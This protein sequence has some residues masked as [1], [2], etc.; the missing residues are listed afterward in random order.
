VTRPDVI[1]AS[2]KLVFDRRAGFVKFHED[3]FIVACGNRPEHSAIACMLPTPL[4]SRLNVIDVDPP[5]IEEWSDWMTKSYGEN[6][7]RRCFA[8]L[9]RFRDENYLIKIPKATETLDPYPTPRT[10][11]S[12]ATLMARG[13]QDKET[14]RGLVGYEVGTK[15]DAFLKVRVD[16][17]ELIREPKLFHELEFDSKYMVCVMLASWISRHINNPAKVFPLVD[18]MSEEKR[19]RLIC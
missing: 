13:I 1:S 14:I 15:F 5:T 7:D 12:L 19:E 18:E 17:N 10:W 16:I 8:F 11:S 2:Y 4:I 3:V 6:W 9:A